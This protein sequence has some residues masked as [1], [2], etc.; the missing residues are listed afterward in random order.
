MVNWKRNILQCLVIAVLMM[1]IVFAWHGIAQEIQKVHK[2]PSSEDV[3]YLKDVPVPHD[4]AVEKKQPAHVCC[5]ACGK[6]MRSDTLDTTMIGMSALVDEVDP[7]DEQSAL[8]KVFLQKQLG[9]YEIG[10]KYNICWEC[11]LKAMG[12]QP[13][14]AYIESLDTEACSEYTLDIGSNTILTIE[15]SPNYVWGIG[16]DTIITV[17]ARENKD[18]TNKYEQ[19]TPDRIEISGDYYNYMHFD[20]DRNVIVIGIRE[21]KR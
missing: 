14:W 13:R 7:K 18:K 4:A 6:D 19:R 21:K 8:R 10:R 3:L 5:D 12:V 2:A 9:D 15:S 11:M 1:L 17:V 16:G 20:S